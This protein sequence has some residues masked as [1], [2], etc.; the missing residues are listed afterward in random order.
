MRYRPFN[1]HGVGV[2]L[3]VHFRNNIFSLKIGNTIIDSLNIWKRIIC[4][5]IKKATTFKFL[6]QSLFELVGYKKK[7]YFFFSLSPLNIQRVNNAS[8]NLKKIDVSENLIK[9]IICFGKLYMPNPPPPPPPC[10][11]Y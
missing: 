2:W 3:R 9:K 1:T 4:V 5:W 10:Q 8:E 6:A 7:S 11:R